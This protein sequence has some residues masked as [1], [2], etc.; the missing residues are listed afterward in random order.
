RRRLLPA[1]AVTLRSAAKPGGRLG[2]QPGHQEAEPRSPGGVAEP[3]EL[4]LARIVVRSVETPLAVPI[5]LDRSFRPLGP[6]HTLEY[7]AARA[8]TP[9]GSGKM[10]PMRSTV[11][12]PNR[13]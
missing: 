4:P 7:S 2:L 13:R 1:L 6:V 3:G 9:G 8:A 12:V 11:P 5:A 10:S